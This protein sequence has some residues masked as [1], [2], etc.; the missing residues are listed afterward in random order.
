MC[1]DGYNIT[2]MFEVRTPH[3]DGFFTARN[4]TFS[5]R[6]RRSGL[7]LT[8]KALAMKRHWWMIKLPSTTK[9]AQP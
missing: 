8:Q 3:N 1:L 5:Y 6:R 7:S 2:H 4:A 9:L